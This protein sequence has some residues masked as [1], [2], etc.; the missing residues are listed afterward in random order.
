[1]TIDLRRCRF[2]QYQPGPIN[3]CSSHELNQIKKLAIYRPESGVEIW[4]CGS[5]KE[6]KGWA[7]EGL[8]V[9]VGKVGRCVEGLAWS[10]DGR[11]FS[12][13][14]DGYLV[15]WDLGRGI[16]KVLSAPS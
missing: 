16:P 2:V 11:L 4:A 10:L 6:S 9:P 8:L 14:L 13:G 12:V 1:M 15:E 5:V 3:L 7:C